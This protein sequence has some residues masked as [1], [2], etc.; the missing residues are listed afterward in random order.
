MKFENLLL[1]I[2]NKQLKKKRQQQTNLENQSKIPE[3][4]LDEDDNLSKYDAIWNELDAIDDYISEGIRIRSKCD[5]YEHS[6]KS[7]NSFLNFEKQRGAQ[8][9]KK[10]SLLVIRK[11]QTRHI[12]QNV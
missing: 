7:I 3:K 11:L 6:E 10:T 9:N 1:T 4:S 2:R 8:N 12:Y 5:W